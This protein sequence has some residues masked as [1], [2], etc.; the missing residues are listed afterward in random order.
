MDER[1]KS[2]LLGYLKSELL[3]YPVPR[4]Y[5][6]YASRRTIDARPPYFS[7]A[8]FFQSMGRQS[9]AV[10]KT[11]ASRNKQ[12]ISRHVSRSWF[13]SWIICMCCC[14]FREHCTCPASTLLLTSEVMLLLSFVHP[15]IPEDFRNHHT[16]GS[17]VE[18]YPGRG[19]YRR[20]WRARSCS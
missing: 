14:E 1:S 17:E 4:R 11:C 20:L 9:V 12:V 16:T 15:S 5:A 19:M 18:E 2:E 13:V 7:V 8:D 3:E 10:N 6:S